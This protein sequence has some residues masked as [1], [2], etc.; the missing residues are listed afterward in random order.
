MRRN[1]IEVDR[2]KNIYTPQDLITI[3]VKRMP[4]TP[5]TLTYLN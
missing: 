3:G 4:P 5:T 2:D 1:K